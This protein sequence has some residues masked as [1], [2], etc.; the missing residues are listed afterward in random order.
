MDYELLEVTIY[1]ITLKG[2]YNDRI[3]WVYYYF[4]FYTWENQVSKPLSFHTWNNVTTTFLGDLSRP[5]MG[6]QGLVAV[7]HPTPVLLPGKSHGR[8]SLVGCS[9]W[10]R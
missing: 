1:A 7:W 5:P 10:G 2:P 3:V 4:L 6:V 8:G 9:P